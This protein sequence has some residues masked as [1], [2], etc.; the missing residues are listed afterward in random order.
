MFIETMKLLVIGVYFSNKYVIR[1]SVPSFNIFFE[2]C[3]A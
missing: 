1:V 3:K 2:S